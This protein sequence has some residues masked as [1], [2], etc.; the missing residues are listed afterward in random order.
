MKR[1]LLIWGTGSQAHV[2]V[3]QCRYGNYQMID[4]ESNEYETGRWLLNF[5][6]GSWDAFVAIGDNAVRERITRR[7]RS[8]GYELTNIISRDSYVSPTV[9]L[10][11]GIYIAPMACVMTH[12]RI[13]N[14][15]II[16]TNASVDHDCDLGD[17][18]HISPCAGL[19]GNVV[20]GDRTWIGLGS[21][22]IHKSWIENDILVAGGSS[23]AGDLWESNSLYAG[24]PAVFKKEI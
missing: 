16:N 17:F 1:N 3:E 6:P 8:K 20:I 23:V 21:S 12:T 22:V 7:L 19:G 2:V 24:N 4:D 13:G 11:T 15:C 9:E 14:G 10:G 18:V 5:H